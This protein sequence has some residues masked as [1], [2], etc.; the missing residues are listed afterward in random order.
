VVDE[1]M[2]TPKSL[3]IED[4]VWI[5]HNVTILANTQ[6]IGRGAIVAAGAVVREPVAPY[7]IVGGVPARV[8]RPRFGAAHIAEIE[9]TRWWTLEPA[10]IAALLTSRPTWLPQAASRRGPKFNEITS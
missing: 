1:W 10:E 6:R 8:L 5:G 3:I 7:M 9:A 4:D 2:I